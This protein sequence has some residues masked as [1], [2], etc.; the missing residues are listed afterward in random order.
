VDGAAKQ[1]TSNSTAVAA[2]VKG[3]ALDEETPE[4]WRGAAGLCVRVC[5]RDVLVPPNL[6]I[7]TYEETCTR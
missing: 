4:L 3:F 1:A 2:T 7:H 5:A 6:Y